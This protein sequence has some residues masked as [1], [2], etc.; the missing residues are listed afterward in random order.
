[1]EGTLLE[2]LMEG[3]MPDASLHVTKEPGKNV[4]TRRVVRGEGNSL[5]P[6]M[7]CAGML[8]HLGEKPM[9]AGQGLNPKRTKALRASTCLRQCGVREP[10]KEIDAAQGN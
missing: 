9:W 7:R 1:M 10:D 6:R 3:T 8:P 4:R 2:R 5:T